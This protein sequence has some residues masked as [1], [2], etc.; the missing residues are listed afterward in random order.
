MVGTGS[1]HLERGYIY[2]FNNP[3]CDDKFSIFVAPI[4]KYSHSL[5]VI[6]LQMKYHIF[7]K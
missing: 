2:G 4:L 6:L 1:E 5:N 3:E 7:I